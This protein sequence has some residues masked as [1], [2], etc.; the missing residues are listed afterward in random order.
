MFMWVP[1]RGGRLPVVLKIPG[2]C[3]RGHV[4]SFE[5]L[6]PASDQIECLHVSPRGAGGGAGE[7]LSDYPHL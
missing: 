7:G 1:E 2:S 3:Q 6:N 4:S 5:S